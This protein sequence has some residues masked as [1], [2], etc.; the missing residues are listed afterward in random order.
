[1]EAKL[2]SRPRPHEPQEAK[3]AHTEGRVRR[4]VLMGKEGAAKGIVDVSR[5]K[6]LSGGTSSSGLGQSVQMKICRANHARAV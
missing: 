4:D 2:I 1:M 5:N 6:I 3:A